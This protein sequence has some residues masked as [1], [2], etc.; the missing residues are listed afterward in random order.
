[1]LRTRLSK[2]GAPGGPDARTSSVATRPVDRRPRPVTSRRTRVTFAKRD[3]RGAGRP[4]ASLVG[5]AVLTVSLAAWTRRLGSAD[6]A[7]AG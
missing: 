1:M 7:V 4:A 6:E 5:A 2:P 3:E